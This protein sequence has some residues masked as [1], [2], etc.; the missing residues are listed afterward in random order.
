LNHEDRVGGRFRHIAGALGGEQLPGALHAPERMR[1]SFGD[2]RNYA[3]QTMTVLLRETRLP[4]GRIEQHSPPV[5]ATE[6]NA[7]TTS[8]GKLSL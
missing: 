2:S 8:R 7:T 3:K 1:K 6:R 5:L 4:R